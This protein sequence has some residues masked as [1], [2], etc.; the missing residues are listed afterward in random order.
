MFSTSKYEGI[1]LACHWSIYQPFLLAHIYSFLLHIGPWKYFFN[2][3]SLH[4]DLKN[5][6]ETKEFI[7][8]TETILYINTWKQSHPRPRDQ[9]KTSIINTQDS[10]LPPEPRNPTP[11]DRHNNNWHLNGHYKS[12]KSLDRWYTETERKMPFHVNKTRETIK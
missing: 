6:T 10:L 8:F 2:R 12:W 7:H 3:K 9:N 11:I 1:P 5:S 4:Q